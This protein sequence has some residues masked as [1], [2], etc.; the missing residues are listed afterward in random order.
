MMNP[1]AAL[2]KRMHRE[3][4][5]PLGCAESCVTRILLAAESE[6]IPV[7]VVGGIITLPQ[8]DPVPHIWLA[9]TGIRV[10]DM[11][12][13]IAEASGDVTK[14][15]VFGVPPFGWAY[16]ACWSPREAVRRIR[17][18]AERVVRS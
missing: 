6:A 8:R 9:A 7:E 14:S 16:R 3:R 12:V 11:S 18:F 5:F 15:R 13:L 10:V 2:L 1:L 17:R 4:P